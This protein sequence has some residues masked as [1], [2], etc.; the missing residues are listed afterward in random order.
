L[1]QWLPKCSSKRSNGNEFRPLVAEACRVVRLSQLAADAG[2]DSEGNHEFARTEHGIR[3]LIPARHGRPTD[4]LPTGRYR[5]LMKV[6][7]DR[8]AYRRRSQVETVVSMIK[9]RQGAHVHARSYHSQCRCAFRQTHLL[10]E[11]LS[12]QAAG[13]PDKEP[14]DGDASARPG[15]GIVLAKGAQAVCGKRPKCPRVLQA[16]AAH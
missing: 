16:G 14:S 12:G 8:A 6:R 7:F 11:P 13:F 3:T 4:K 15:E 2:Y 9:R 5:Q 1:L 10:V